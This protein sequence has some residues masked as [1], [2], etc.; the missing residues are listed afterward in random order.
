MDPKDFYDEMAPFYHLISWFGFDASIQSH[1]DRLD[2]VIKEQWGNGMRTL[3]DV[4]CGIGTQA[5]GLANLGYDVTASDLSPK[6]V[7]RAVQEAAKRNVKIDFFVSD[8]RQISEVQQHRFD[9]VLSADNSIPHLLSDKEILSA[10]QQLYRCCKVG[11]GC[12]VSVRDYEKEDDHDK[13][14]IPY[15]IREWD[16]KRFYIFQVRDYEGLIY[17]VSMFFIEDDGV[18]KPKT[19]VMRTKYYAIRIDQ[20][21]AL[22]ELAGFM[23]VKRLD[24]V[25]FQPIIVGSKY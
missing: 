22:M 3:L 2:K 13:K 18:G 16:G 5:I 14:M 25:Y 12:L 24:D 20:L 15:G 8:M 17:D 10:F 4:S 11:G 7:A 21:T 9:I 6:A 1:G 19:H 23:D